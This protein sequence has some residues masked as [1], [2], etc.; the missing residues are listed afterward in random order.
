MTG[1]RPTEATDI[2]RR[3]DCERRDRDRDIDARRRAK[4]A[5]RDRA[6]ADFNRMIGATR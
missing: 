2:K 4:R 3:R 1:H 6:Q 5:L